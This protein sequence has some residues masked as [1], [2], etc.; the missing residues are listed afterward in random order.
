MERNREAAWCCGA[1]GSVREAYPEFN[2]WTAAVRVEE[3]G[4]TGAEVIASACPGCEKNL[5]EA[6]AAG[7]SALRVVDVLELVEQAL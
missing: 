6:V 1:G 5:G 3:A 2:A 4:A 7:D